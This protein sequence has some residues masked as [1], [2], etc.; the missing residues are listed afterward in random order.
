MASGNE[1]GIASRLS[2]GCGCGS[3][4][5]GASIHGA[6]RCPYAGGRVEHAGWATAAALTGGAHPAVT[7]GKKIKNVFSL[8]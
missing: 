5:A 6:A 1:A 7:Q 2:R 8:R 4:R 3:A